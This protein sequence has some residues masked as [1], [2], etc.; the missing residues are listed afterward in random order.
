VVSRRCFFGSWRCFHGSEEE[1]GCEC[2]AIS[3]GGVCWSEHLSKYVANIDDVARTRSAGGLVI[4]KPNEL[5]EWADISMHLKSSLGDAC[6]S[7][8][9]I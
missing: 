9:P 5:E 1:A 2:G 8:L 4:Y 6:P 7:P 3:Q